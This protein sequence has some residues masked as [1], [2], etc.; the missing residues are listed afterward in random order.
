MPIAKGTF[1]LLTSTTIIV[2]EDNA[3]REGA[4]SI[5]KNLMP[6]NVKVCSANTSIAVKNELKSAVCMVKYQA[7]KIQYNNIHK[8]G[9][10]VEVKG[11]MEKPKNGKLFKNVARVTPHPLIKYPHPHLQ[12]LRGLMQ[13]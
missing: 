4:F 8:Y 2:V 12:A 13:E 7:V 10:F 1:T 5:F 6:R 9:T 3:G 11:L